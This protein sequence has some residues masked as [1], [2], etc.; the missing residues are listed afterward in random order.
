[1]T[2]E[3][4]NNFVENML[5]SF[6]IAKY[7][8]LKNKK[9]KFIIITVIINTILSTI[10]SYINVVGI[11]QTMLIQ[12]VLCFFLYKYNNNFSFQNVIISLFCN[13]LLFIADYFSI[14]LLSFLYSTTPFQIYNIYKIYIYHIILSKAIFI[15]MIVL[16]LLKKPLLFTKIKIK[17][18]NHLLA[19]E[20]LIIMVMAYYFLSTI[21]SK[22]FDYSSSIMFFCFILLF[23][24]FC[25]VFNSIINMNQQIYENRL[26]DEQEQY[27][28]ENLKNLNS[29]K[30]NIDNTEHRINYILQSIEFDLKEKNYDNVLRKI[31]ISKELVHKIS[32]V[33]CTNNEL[34]DFM[35]NLEIKFFLQNSKQIKICAFISQNHAYDR[36]EIIN[37]IIYILKLLYTY[38]NK[39]ELFIT[40]SENNLLQVKFIILNS[41]TSLKKDIEKD[42]GQISNQSIQIQEN[43]EIIILQYEE[44]L[45]EY[46]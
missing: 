24:S 10:L 35:L 30:M 38:V 42:I 41:A 22:N 12:C 14:L 2:F 31:K 45:N 36:L 43:K 28:S 9:K 44:D 39:L 17:E 29:I 1:M 7:I 6:F 15:I 33:L 27:R 46:M 5:I 37:N 26:K 23:F 8:N 25:Y 13:I 34:F 19:L 16:S 20:L 40:E 32:P 18:I 3:I 11:T 4:I 21:L